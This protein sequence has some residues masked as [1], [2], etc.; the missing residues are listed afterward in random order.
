[1]RPRSPAP[2]TA[3]QARCGNRRRSA[4]RSAG[5]GSAPR[6]ARPQTRSASCWPGCSGYGAGGRDRGL[7]CAGI[8]RLPC[9]GPPSAASS[10]SPGPSRGSRAVPSR[11]SRASRTPPWSWARVYTPIAPDQRLQRDRLGGGQRDVPARTVH[12]LAIALPSEPDVGSRYVARQHRFEFLWIRHSR[13][14]R[15]LDAAFPCQKLASWCSE[16]FFA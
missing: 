16:S 6:F 11:S 1:M 2:P 3:T 7:S 12:M 8:P 4:S 14:G 15:M 5:S 9:R 13:A 10:V